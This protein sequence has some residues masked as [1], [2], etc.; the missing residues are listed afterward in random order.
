MG[1][2]VGVEAPCKPF[3]R[4][5]QE[6]FERF[7]EVEPLTVIDIGAGRGRF[8]RWFMSNFDV[9]LYVAIEP[10]PKSFNYLRGVVATEVPQGDRLVLIRGTWEEVRDVF[11]HDRFKVVVLWDVAMFMDLTGVHGVSD[12]TEAI[13]REV[14]H[15]VKMAERYVL[16]SLHPVKRGLVPKSR[17]RE[18]YME[19]EK[20]CRVVAKRYLNRVYEVIKK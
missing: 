16:F 10:Y 11:I 20:Y 14:P 6:C 15:W 4:C 2:V 19:F 17:F 8:V 1:S 18:L 7:R 13:K 12:Y 5:V 9:E 3:P